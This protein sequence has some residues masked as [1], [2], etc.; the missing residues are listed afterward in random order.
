MGFLV[1]A[2]DNSTAIYSLG[3]EFAEKSKPFQVRKVAQKLD[4]CIIIY[5]STLGTMKLPKILGRGGDQS[6]PKISSSFSLH[7]ASTKPKALRAC[8]ARNVLKTK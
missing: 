3:R 6:I 1:S 7:R 4:G 8:N 2:L 5:S